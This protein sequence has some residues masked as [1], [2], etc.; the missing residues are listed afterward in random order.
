M[1]ENINLKVLHKQVKDRPL[2]KDIAR[3]AK[4]SQG[5]LSNIVAGRRKANPETKERIAR[6]FRRAMK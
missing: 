1:S 3:D 4:M 2:L 5:Q 6:A